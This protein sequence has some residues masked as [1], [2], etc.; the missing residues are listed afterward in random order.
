MKA[1]KI[2]AIILSICVT[3]PIYY[4]LMYKVLIAIGASELMMFL[5][6]TYLPISIIIS[7]IIKFLVDAPKQ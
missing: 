6:W 4:Y 1:L 7:I 2:V 3:M 5:F